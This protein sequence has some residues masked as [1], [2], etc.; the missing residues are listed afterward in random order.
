VA[1][2]RI[3]EPEAMDT[4][5]EAVEYDSMDHS[6]VNRVFVTDLLAAGKIAGDVLDLGTGTGQIPIELCHRTEDVRVM[7]VDLAAYMLDQARINIELETL[8]DRIVFD[9]IDAKTL[10]HGDGQ[11]DVVMS[12]SIIHH[13][14]D[15]LPVMAEAVRVTKSGGIVFFRDLIRP[16]DEESLAQLVA[17]YAA[18]CNE[19]QTKMFSDSLRAAFTVQEIQ[20]LVVE[21]GLEKNTVTAT[22]DR[23]WTWPATKP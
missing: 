14:P 21:L 15:P 10:P 13:V 20:E 18:D 3:P 22:S 9:L 4:F 16:V 5:E 8:T 1:V 17:T 12:N 7:G 6:E 11:F 23:H 2:Q 19:I